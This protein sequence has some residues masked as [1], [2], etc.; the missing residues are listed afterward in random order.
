MET[1]SG[2][3]G[4]AS[5][6]YKENNAD[7]I[8]ANQ[9]NEAWTASLAQVG[10]AVEPVLT[11]VKSMGA[12][13]LTKLVPVI[14]KML[15]NL[16]AIG[17]AVAGIAAALV[18]YKVAAIAATAAEKGMT[19]AQYA[20]AAAQKALNVAMNANPIGLIILAITAL[21]TA[22]VYLW[23]NCE[24]FRNFWINLW[25]KIKSAALKVADALKEL[26][27]KIY[28]A[29]SGAI[30]RVQQWGT[31]MVNKAKTGMKNLVTN[32][33][34][35]LKELPGK[36]LSIGANL[37]TGLWNG[38]QNKLAWLKQKLSSFATSVLSSIKKFFGVH[39]PSRETAWIGE[40]LDQGL[41]EGVLDNADQPIDAM[42][43]VTGGVLGAAQN[44]DGMSVER[45]LQRNSV[46]AQAAAATSGGLTDKLD[47]ILAAIERGQILTID[48]K[49]LVGHT[50]AM[51]DDE[52]GQR[53]A[54][55][56]RGAL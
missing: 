28:N 21:V 24:D 43:K 47:K 2:L 13:L 32:V 35:T 36:V 52:L 18:S 12:E 11:S 49:Q 48:G 9:A 54:L 39:S 33:I 37:V 17:T 4:E 55:A 45:S 25:E 22:F 10:A 46:A 53:R 40:M 7:V 8:A 30:Q 6:A 41:A 34:N 51:Y 20:A 31:D 56:A 27:S 23:N 38:V 1:L 16:P 15:D 50:A 19:I 5:E 3:Y 44:I 29:I 26:P 42:S 14:E